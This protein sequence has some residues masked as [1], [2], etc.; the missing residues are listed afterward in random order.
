MNNT[1]WVLI[2]KE[3]DE[4]Y[5]IVQW[6]QD[7]KMTDRKE[8]VEHWPNISGK[9]VF[10]KAGMGELKLLKRLFYSKQHNDFKVECFK[11]L[12]VDELTDNSYEIVGTNTTTGASDSVTTN[13]PQ[14]A[15]ALADKV[16]NRIKSSENI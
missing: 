1:G 5:G 16:I 13:V 15:I 12:D 9:L 14:A 4:F 8:S 10:C 3:T 6:C 7:G 2:S 11:L